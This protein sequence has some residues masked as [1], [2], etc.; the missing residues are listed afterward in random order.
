MNASCAPL[1]APIHTVGL[2]AESLSGVVPLTAGPSNQGSAQLLKLGA[3]A[4][5]TAGDAVA[6]FNDMAGVLD[7]GLHGGT[8]KALRGGAAF[9]LN[10]DSLIPG[11]AVSG[12]IQV[13]ATTVTAK[14]TTAAA[15]VPV[16][17]FVAH[18]AVGGGS[19]ALAQVTGSAAGQAIAGSTYAP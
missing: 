6:R 12:S 3:A 17:M 15:G 7:H 1:V 10:G 14:L 5:A 11:V 8:S 19:G 16:A 13:S 2:Y 9:R 4:V 18:W